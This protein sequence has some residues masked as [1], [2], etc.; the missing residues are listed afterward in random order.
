MVLLFDK[1]V[2]WMQVCSGVASRVHQKEHGGVGQWECTW[3]GWV[4]SFP[5]AEHGSLSLSQGGCTRK[6]SG[7]SS[8]GCYT[9]LLG[10]LEGKCV[11]G[12]EESLTYSKCLMNV[13]HCY[14]R[15]CS[16]ICWVNMLNEWDESVCF[17]PHLCLSCV[18]PLPAF[19]RRCPC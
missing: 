4:T 3:L 2:G 11:K 15:R 10:L 19:R 7:F 17:P 9:C 5:H 8:I 13:C 18:S 14:H 16:N 1:T 6:N 12:L